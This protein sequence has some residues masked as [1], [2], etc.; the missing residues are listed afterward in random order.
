MTPGEAPPA[1]PGLPLVCS[2]CHR[3]YPADDFPHQC[4]ACHGLYEFGEPLQYAPGSSPFRGLEAFRSMLPLRAD[5]TLV[6][7]GEGGTPLVGVR[8]RGRDVFFKCEHLNP[9]GSFKDRGSCVLVSALLAGGVREAVEDSS[10]N[11]GASLAAYAARAGI[12]L[13]VFV[14]DS[15]SPAKRAQMEAFGARV[16]PILGPRAA[17]SEAVLEAVAQGAVYASHAYLPLG[18]AGMATI[19][20]ELVEELGRAPGAVVVPVGQGTLLLGCAAGF[21]AL[22]GA[23]RAERLPALVGVQA[24]ACAPIWAVWTGGSAGLSWTSEGATRAEGVRISHPLRGDAIL[25]AVEG[26]RGRMVAVSE[27]DIGEGEHQ[28]ARLGFYVE[29]TSAVVWRGL[30]DNLD[31]LPDPVVVILTGSGYK[32]PLYPRVT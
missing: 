25:A 20:F 19:A 6:S 13:R 3:P 24:R 1:A 30:M 32:T 27:E 21:Q 5:A 29:P 2:N 16:V 9:T 23:G 11:A 22:L 4:P 10:G 8:L 26:S 17:A 12:D 28:L 15:A 14:P 7:L 31:A 18:Q